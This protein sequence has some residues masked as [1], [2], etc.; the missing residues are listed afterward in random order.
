MAFT[1]EVPGEAEIKKKVQGPFT[2]QVPDEA[3]I[4]KE[5][6]EQVKPVPKEMAQIQAIVDRNVEAIITLDIDEL[7]ESPIKQSF[8]SYG[9]DSM[10]RSAT[11]NYYLQMKVGTLSKDDHEGGVVVKG[12][13]DLQR[14]LRKLDPNRIDFTGKG[15]FIK[16][17]DPVR[18]YFDKYEKA[19]SVIKK[20]FDTL[21]SGKE[22]LKDDN[23]TLELEQKDMRVLTKKLNKEIELG[24]KMAEAIEAA[25]ARNEDPEKRKF[26]NEEVLL[27]LRLMIMDMLQMITVN[28][29]AII[30]I[31]IVRRNNKE[32]I[33]GVER[34]QI[35]TISALRTAVMVAGA[36]LKQKNVLDKL[37]WIN[38][39]TDRFIDYNA[40]M[41]NEQEKAIQERLGDAN[42][43]VETLI[44]AYANVMEALDD[45]SAYKQKVQPKIKK[46]IDQL[47]V[48]AAKGEEQIQK[49]ETGHKLEQ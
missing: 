42:I 44:V 37:D 47:I 16:L 28:Q 31:E 15:I 26:I 5:V 1:M 18:I 23:T 24:K 35:V 29:Q 19:D 14:E 7:L 8:E 6:Q 46:E 38:D 11:Q 2:M 21:E 20:I 40:R 10:K 34:A 43:S 4:R 39:F 12:L 41:L 32:L 27:P 48:L 33:R 13:G 22:G 17:I 9:K 36:L 49:L 45:L 3:E 30:A 25:N